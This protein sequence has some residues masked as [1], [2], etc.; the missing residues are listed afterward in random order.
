[1]LAGGGTGG[2]IYPA[3]AVGKALARRHPEARVLFVGSAHG[4]ERDL[5]PREGFDFRPIVVSGFKRELSP[6][7][8]VTVGKAAVGLVQS[9][10]I[11]GSFRPDVVVGT[12]G[13][14]S[15]PVVLAAV[16]LGVPTVIHEQNVVP[17]ATNRFLSRYARVVAIS[18]EESRKSLA[19]PSRAVLTGNPIRPEVLRAT[20]E[21]GI[22]A[23]GLRP[24]FRTVLAF[25][26]S[27]GSERIND[28]L[29]RALP[30]LAEKK[31][32]QYLLSTGRRNYD[33]VIALAR[34][35]GLPVRSSS[36]GGIPE[37]AGGD[38]IV[39]PYIYNMPLALA[40]ADLVISR[41]GAITLA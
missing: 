13:Y 3:L 18:W 17:G 21:E 6:G 26:G 12:G 15:G 36:D 16:I 29:I 28:A 5:V 11:V 27:Q 35:L 25:G 2:H 38:I 40:C 23:L 8:V 30:A 7:L 19:L 24:N 31:G 1:L 41:S 22:K 34:D 9:L 32:V 14:A 37:S 33:R 39:A 20:R 4:L 10:A